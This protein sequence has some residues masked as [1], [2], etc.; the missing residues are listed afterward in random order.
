ME[1]GENHHEDVLIWN[2]KE[3]KVESP[4]HDNN[5]MVSF[6]EVWSNREKPMSTDDWTEAGTI[7]FIQISWYIDLL[8]VFDLSPQMPD[9]ISK[10]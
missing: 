8:L 5:I 7:D 1:V 9:L 10:G 6:G 4:D 2:L 3:S